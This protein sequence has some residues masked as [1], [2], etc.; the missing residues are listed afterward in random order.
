MRRQRCSQQTFSSLEL[1][2]VNWTARQGK[3]GS[4]RPPKVPP[5]GSAAFDI[6]GREA[7][8]GEGGGEEA[9]QPG[10]RRT[11]RSASPE[12]QN[13][14]RL[15]SRAARHCV[16]TP[17]LGELGARPGTAVTAGFRDDRGAVCPL[18]ESGQAGGSVADREGLGCSPCS[19]PGA[20]SP[21]L[22]DAGLPFGAPRPPCHPWVAFAAFCAQAGGKSLGKSQGG[23]PLRHR[24]PK[25]LEV[26]SSPLVAC[27]TRHLIPKQYQSDRT[28]SAV[29]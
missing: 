10:G 21:D 26:Q 27:G 9:R 5:P 18:Q 7:G 25:A 16:Q 23:S 22:W 19:S 6:M 2:E 12:L 13:S 3:G 8:S 14:R 15:A 4:R 24:W 1:C 20:P 29:P 11:P 28:W 17:A